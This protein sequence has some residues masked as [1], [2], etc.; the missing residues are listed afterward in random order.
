MGQGDMQR[1]L[2]IRKQLYFVFSQLNSPFAFV[3]GFF[4]T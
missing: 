3:V 4:N 2:S 1:P